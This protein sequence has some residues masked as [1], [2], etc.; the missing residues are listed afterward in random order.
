MNELNIQRFAPDFSSELISYYAV[1]TWVGGSTY[2]RPSSI[3]ATVTIHSS[4]FYIN[5]EIS[6]TTDGEIL[7]GSSYYYSIIEDPTAIF[8]SSNYTYEVTSVDS[9]STA[10]KIVYYVTA[11]Y[12][13]GYSSSRVKTNLLVKF[14]DTV[15]EEWYPDWL[16]FF[17]NFGDYS[18]EITRFMI[19]SSKP[20]TFE[21]DHEDYFNSY[22]ILGEVD[23]YNP[24]Y[25]TTVKECAVV[26]IGDYV[27]SKTLRLKYGTYGMNID[28]EMSDNIA[29]YCGWDS[30]NP[31][32][33]IE[34]VFIQGTV[35]DLI[36]N[37]H[38]NWGTELY[39]KDKSGNEV[40][41]IFGES[42]G[43]SLT[44]ITK[45]EIDGALIGTIEA[46]DENCPLF[47]MVFREEASSSYSYPENPII[48]LDEANKTRTFERYCVVE[49]AR[50]TAEIQDPVF[51]YT[52]VSTG[53]SSG[54]YG[55]WK[56]NGDGTYSIT[57]FLTKTDTELTNEGYT[58]GST[59]AGYYNY[60]G[61]AT[62]Y[63]PRT[64]L[65]NARFSRGE[66]VSE[67]HD[68]KLVIQKPIEARFTHPDGEQIINM[69]V[70][71][72]HPYLD[73]PLYSFE[74]IVTISDERVQAD[75]YLEGSKHDKSRVEVTWASSWPDQYGPYTF[76]ELRTFS[77][78]ESSIGM[79]YVYEEISNPIF[80]GDKNIVF[81]NLTGVLPNIKFGDHQIGKVIFGG[82]TIWKW[83]GWDD[84]FST[85]LTHA[86]LSTR[87]NADLAGY[88]H[89]QIAAGNIGA[90]GEGV[91][92]IT[93]TMEGTSCT[94]IQGMTWEEWV[95]SEYNTVEA[96]IF[97]D[98]IVWLGS[99]YP[100]DADQVYLGKEDIITPNGVYTIK[101]CCFEAG[102]QVLTSLDRDTKNI[103]D[104]RVGDTII[105]YNEDTKEFFETEVSALKT[106]PNVIDIAIVTLEDNSQV[107]MNAYHPLLTIEGYKSLTQHEGLL[108]LTEEDIVVTIN[109]NK[110][111][112][113]IERYIQE[114][115]EMYN[116]TVN[117]K[118]H[119]YVV[120]SIVT[121]N[122]PCVS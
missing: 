12:L 24:Y 5:A 86:M 10:N 28:P 107:R 26:N 98:D 49:I 30:S 92:Y 55:A 34:K 84:L 19:E 9:T 4:P 31:F 14:D 88:T 77:L 41:S 45:V 59:H 111:I 37:Y 1:F 6:G 121:H 89:E 18:T 108:L 83:E 16:E 116:L 106:N 15:T 17:Y 57:N 60:T 110:T 94:A 109:G 63:W 93:F 44:N 65:Q 82:K 91:T 67:T 53:E 114:P 90:P 101:L 66:L 115:E 97:N 22:D 105:S 102:T 78:A 104:I 73:E 21:F 8:Y 113:S 81:G 72:Y 7:I 103:E 33:N 74:D 35:G 56:D 58:S 50:N 3:C 69:V 112:K 32:A 46:I 119:N 39:V 23:V 25:T 75:G 120:N 64:E 38:Y 13:E 52:N 43:V 95:N 68:Y 87:T 79:V 20:R 51:W 99:G 48:I 76:D 96:I 27:T 118:Y 47:G 100:S 122:V 117:N 11:T 54:V 36:V 85:E 70:S 80:T 71:G 40:L 42:S 29:T 62:R 61:M 2:T